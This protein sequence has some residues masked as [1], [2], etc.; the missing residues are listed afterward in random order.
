MNRIAR[1]PKLVLA[2]LLIVMLVALPLGAFAGASARS[3]FA[4]TKMTSSQR[5]F[6]NKL[7]NSWKYRWMSAADQRGLLWL[8]GRSLPSPAAPT[9]GRSVALG[10]PVPLLGAPANVRVNDPSGDGA[11]DPNMTTQ[12]E[13]SIA[14]SGSNVV[15]GYNDDG[16][17]PFNLQAGADMTGYSW[18]SDGGTTWHDSVLPDPVRG[19]N[20]GDPVVAVDGS[21]NFYFASLAANFSTFA[22]QVVVGKSTDGGQTF[23]TPTWVAG[24]RNAYSF[25]D[26]P[27]LTVG[28]DP[29]NP[30]TDIVYVSWTDFGSSF[31]VQVSASAD[32]GA[33]WSFPS[34]A[35]LGTPITHKAFRRRFGFEDLETGSSLAVDPSTG[36]LYVAYEQ[37]LDITPLNAKQF[38]IRKEWVT[39]STDGGATFSLPMHVGTVNAIGRTPTFACGN[40]LNF[41]SDSLIRVTEFPSIGVGPSGGVYVA[42]DSANLTLHSSRVVLANSADGGATWSHQTMAA[43][44]EAFMPALAADASGVNV[45]YY[46]R[47]S[48][49]MLKA[50]VATSTDGTTFTTGD[51][52]SVAF[53]VPA[54]VPNFDPEIA[55]CY[56]GDYNSV[57]LSGGTLYAAWGDNRDTVSNFVWPGGRPDPN[58]YF[59]KL[60]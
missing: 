9:A 31:G 38:E 5:A 56:M 21:G 11:G 60:P 6:L 19:I 29:S 4:S 30:S 37:M 23:S 51:L 59:A 3:A 55:P 15:V 48:A 36:T 53:G 16:R 52:S 14:A 40:T 58:V 10:S 35:S 22:I 43:G 39:K 2:G 20:F 28:P 45:L 24:E 42:Y 32:G 26:K 44:S 54:L 57:A 7:A 50:A 12:S 46:E 41:G 33:T 27:W 18:S 49:T 13:T 8:L 25:A 34:P 1:F 47:T 17:T